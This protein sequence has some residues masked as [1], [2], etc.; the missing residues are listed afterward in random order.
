MVWGPEDGKIFIESYRSE[1]APE[2]IEA[3]F[4]F[5]TE[6][7]EMETWQT[8]DWDEVLATAH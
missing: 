7:G 8:E 4:I 5:A 6:S 3:L 2:R 1:N